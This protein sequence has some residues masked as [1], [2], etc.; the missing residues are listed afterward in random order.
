M[1]IAPLEKFGLGGLNTDL[2]REALS[3]TYF[4]DGLDMR[5]FDDALRGVFDWE[6]AETRIR[7]F[8]LITDGAEYT[9]DVLSIKPIEIAQWTRS[10]TDYLDILTVGLDSGDLGEI[11]ITGEDEDP[12]VITACSFVNPF[13]YDPTTG[14]NAFI[15]N[16]LAIVNPTTVGPMYSFDRD[17]FYSLPNWFGEPIGSVLTATSQYSVYQIVTVLDPD[18]VDVGGSITAAVG[19]VFTATGNDDITLLGDVQILHPYNAAR[20]SVY[21]GRLVAVNLFNDLDDG[22]PSNDIA[23][24]IEMAYSSSV[25]EI[26]S[27]F[28]IEWYA[29]AN[30]TAGNAFLTQTPGR[31]TDA[32]QLG[33]FLMVYKTDAVLRMQDTGEPLFVTGETA[34]LDDGVLSYDCVADI[35]GNRHFVIGNYGIYIHAGGPEK[36]IISSDKTTIGF[37]DNL[38]VDLDDRALTFVFHDSIQKEVWACYRHRAADTGASY[39]G[40]TRALVYSYEKGTFYTRSLPNVTKIIETEVNG[41][42]EII[43]ASLDEDAGSYVTGYLYSLSKDSY[44]PDGYVQFTTRELGMVESV[45]ALN[46]VYPTSRDSFE[47]KI[48]TTP[49]PTE[50]DMNLVT[51]YT[52]NPTVDYKLDFRELGRYYTIRVQMDEAVNPILFM[53]KIDMNLEGER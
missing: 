18:W 2:P 40:C 7:L 47:L 45:K 4:D 51:A 31:V 33:E 41:I 12:A 22:D 44:V 39:K 35:G 19:H 29:S 9:T 25:S 11:Y 5:P 14:L 8:Q 46:G 53:V 23:S 20:M 24:P 30:N 15:F 10:G 48:T 43:A 6:T 38:P 1:P 37:Y 26:A 28:D 21:N 13:T 42:V 16:E 17:N 27:I 50:P 36:E 3:T 49:T 32:K 34:F 52:F